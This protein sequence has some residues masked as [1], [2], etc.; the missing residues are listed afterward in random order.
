MR[1]IALCLIL[2]TIAATA[3]EKLVKCSVSINGQK[4][5]QVDSIFP[6]KKTYLEVSGLG[7]NMG[8]Q[9]VD[10]STG[11]SLFI[12]GK[13]FT[14][15]N[16]YDGKTYV[17]AQAIASTFGYDLKESQ[18]GL[19]VDFWSKSGA[20]GAAS[21]S[22]SIS[23]R[24]KVTSPIPEY[25]T[26]RLTVSIRNNS[27]KPLRLN[28]KD[29]FVTDTRGTRYNCEGNFD[30]GVSPKSSASADRLYFNVPVKV[31]P[32]EIHVVSPEGQEL[33]A[34]RI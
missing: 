31:T 13:P 20:V 6:N 23:K 24:E 19:V 4:T 16:R 22:V 2:L 5:F 8:W 18:Q 28:A 7:T 33:G 14:D 1:Q 10:R 30:I 25:E 34:A 21:V 9:I 26:L 17:S 12:D 15:F 3:A 11:N 27:E 29:F 32:K